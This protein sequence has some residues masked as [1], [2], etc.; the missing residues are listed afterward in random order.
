MFFHCLAMMASLAAMLLARRP[1]SFEFSYGYDR[2]E[3]LAAFAACTSLIFV[4]GLGASPLLRLGTSTGCFSETL[5][6]GSP[7]LFPSPDLC[8]QPPLH[9]QVCLFIGVQ[10][11]HRMTDP[12]ELSGTLLL[13]FGL[14]GLAIN[15]LGLLLFGKRNVR[16]A[17][18]ASLSSQPALAAPSHGH[19]G[20]PARS[21][22]SHQTNLQVPF[23]GV[24]RKRGCACMFCVSARIR[25]RTAAGLCR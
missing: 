4:S 1:A 3:V 12:T 21:V 24:G 6:A 17:L 20:G 16:F 18:Q 9:P 15:I 7:C 13:E 23:T 22:N 8:S 10:A 2:F 11:L 19:G 14:C 5:V 25:A